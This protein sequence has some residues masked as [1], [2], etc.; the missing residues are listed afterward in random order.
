L[1]PRSQIDIFIFVLQQDGGLLQACVNATTLALMNAGVPLQDFVCA[2]SAGVYTTEPLLDLTALEEGDIPHATVALLPRSGALT[3]VN[4]ET[5]LH[6]DR[7][8]QILRIASEAG[9]VVHA[10]MRKHIRARTRNLVDAMG[11]TR[12]AGE[13]QERRHDEMDES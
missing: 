5:R 7:F 3:L 8:E 1:Y 2:V 9:H 10:E 12:V 4:M 6:V 11:G 13:Q